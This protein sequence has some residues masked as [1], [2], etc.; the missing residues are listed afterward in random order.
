LV[1]DLLR[2]NPPNQQKSLIYG[3]RIIKLI[4]YF[5]RSHPSGSLSSKEIYKLKVKK[6]MRLLGSS[7]RL[8]SS[9]SCVW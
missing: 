2:K 3:L 6:Q 8:L 7:R 1:K 9:G 5:L 4:I